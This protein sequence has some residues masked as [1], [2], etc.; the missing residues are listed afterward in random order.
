MDERGS[1]NWERGARKGPRPLVL[2]ALVALLVVGGIVGFFVWLF[3][4]P[5]SRVARQISDD[6]PGVVLQWNYFA[7]TNGD[8]LTLVLANE[9]TRQEALDLQ[10]RV[11]L[12]LMVR[13]QMRAQIVIRRADNDYQLNGD[14]CPPAAASIS[15][16]SWASIVAPGAPDP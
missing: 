14:E 15:W 8:T 9:V 2:L 3:N 13:E 7:G 6:A 16:V 5:G 12:P 11:V 10:C 1:S 4:S